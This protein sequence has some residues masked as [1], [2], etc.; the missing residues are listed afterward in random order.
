M[1][2]LP[3][4]RPS[5][6]GTAT[7]P[8]TPPSLDLDDP[9]ITGPCDSQSVGGPNNSSPLPEFPRDTTSLD[10]PELDSPKNPATS[11][12]RGGFNWNRENGWDMEWADIAEFEVWL[13]E[14]QLAKSIEF[15]LSSTKPGTWLWT[16]KRT[17]VCSRQ[18]S[19]GQKTYE[20]KHP[21]W[22]R[23][24]DSKKTGCHC[25]IV[26]KFYPH[27]LTILGR[28]SQE[29]D[30]EIQLANVAYTRLSQAA[31][32]QIKIMLKQRVDQK[33]IVRK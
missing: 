13:R 18:I 33:E 14:E 8:S 2:I 24:F 16:K 20:R 26:I 9:A 27:T 22:K 4:F 23:K 30:H 3:I 12:R 11:K 21:D 32:D 7:R 10:S 15:V 28:Y 5:E 19:G 31:Q 6:Q 29:H 17:Y 25:Q 1:S